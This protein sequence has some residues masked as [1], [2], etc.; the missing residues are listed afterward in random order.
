MPKN[1]VPVPATAYTTEYF[2]TIDGYDE[3]LQT[4]GRA[5][6]A[7]LNEALTMAGA[8]AGLRVL[9]LGCGRGEVLLR[10]LD[11]GA[12]AIGLDYAPDALALT[13]KILPAHFRGLVQADAQ[14]LPFG[15]N[16]LDL[17]LALDIVE[18]L[19][20]VELERMLAEAYR[21]LTPGGRLIVHTMPN[22]WYYR[23][24]YPL[25]RLFQ[26]LRGMHL[27]RDPHDRRYYVKLMHVN[28]QSVGTLARNLHRAGFHVRLSLRNVQ[29]FRQ[30]G[31]GLVRV[32]MRI[33]AEVYPFAWIFCNDLFAV[34]TKS[35]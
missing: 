23:Y 6:T 24:G 11:E 12:C 18:H 13:R 35:A 10:S 15:D 7:R 19:H 29:D 28:E 3:Y 5:L 31:S 25:Y 32:G 20:Q 16:S 33:L 1:D 4:S 17:I 8:I 34:A 2:S 26:H 22:L 27:P 14:R 21:V 9:D 30:E